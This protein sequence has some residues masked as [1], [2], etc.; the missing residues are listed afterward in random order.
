MKHEEK[1][2]ERKPQQFDIYTR[3]PNSPNKKNAKRCQAKPDPTDPT[4]SGKY[5][6]EDLVPAGQGVLSNIE[7]K[8]EQQARTDPF[9]A[10]GV[11]AADKMTF[12]LLKWV[13]NAIKHDSAED[14][15]KFKGQSFVSKADLVK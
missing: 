11:G 15:P 1:I 6:A 7:I 5:N 14:D 3:G 10:L 13:F 4:K 2:K 12:F 8:R 9:G